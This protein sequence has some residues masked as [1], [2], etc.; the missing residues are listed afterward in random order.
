MFCELD[1]L[2]IVRLE[3]YSELWNLNYTFWKT[4]Q[5]YESSWINVIQQNERVWS[6]CIHSWFGKAQG[7]DWHWN[8]WSPWRSVSVSQKQKLCSHLWGPFRCVVSGRA[9]VAP[10]ASQG[11]AILCLYLIWA[12]FWSLATY[13]PW[14]PFLGTLV[15]YAYMLSSCQGTKILRIPIMVIFHALLPFY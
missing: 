10:V 3:Q 1:A 4:K 8:G 12:G 2:N 6:L 14:K 11:W 13:G 9:K 5:E 7:S 15:L